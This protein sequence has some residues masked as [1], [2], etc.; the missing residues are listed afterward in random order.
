MVF[1]QNF[2]AYIWPKPTQGKIWNKFASASFIEWTFLYKPCYLLWF[3]ILKQRH[4]ICCIINRRFRKTD[5]F[6]RVLFYIPIGSPK[7]VY[8][9]LLI[10][11]IECSTNRWFETALKSNLYTQWMV[12]KHAISSWR[13]HLSFF[14]SINLQVV[15]LESKRYSEHILKKCR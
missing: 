9:L 15:N 14:S 2:I 12:G 13:C 4:K 3:P 10:S 1:V 6:D 5:F 7:N 11:R 8:N